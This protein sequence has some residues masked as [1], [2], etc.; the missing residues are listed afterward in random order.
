MHKYFTKAWFVPSRISQNCNSCESWNLYIRISLA[1]GESDRYRKVSGAK[2]CPS[3]YAANHTISKDSNE[4]S[5]IPRWILDKKR[6]AKMD[7]TLPLKYF[8]FLKTLY[9]LDQEEEKI[10]LFQ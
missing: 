7:D 4:K 6:Y 2:I 5:G 10:L 1:L 9:I 3:L 8:T